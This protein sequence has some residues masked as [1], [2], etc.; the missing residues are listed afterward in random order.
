M[1]GWVKLSS[2]GVFFC[3]HARVVAVAAYDATSSEDG[4]SER[5]ELRRVAASWCSDEPRW[6]VRVR[7]LVSQ[8]SIRRSRSEP[9]VG[10]CGVASI[11][12]QADA[13]RARA[14]PIAGEPSAVSIG[15]A[16][17][18]AKV[19]R[20][21]GKTC[22]VIC[23]RVDVR[24]AIWD[25]VASNVT[26]SGVGSGAGRTRA[27]VRGVGTLAAFGSFELDA[28]GVDTKRERASDAEL[29]DASG[30][31]TDVARGMAAATVH[32]GSVAAASVLIERAGDADEG[33]R[34]VG[35]E[36]ATVG[37]GERRR[38]ADGA[39]GGERANRGH[40]RTWTK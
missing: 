24:S 11:V 30:V 40:R 9:L 32:D 35:S 19:G 26:A 12:V 5:R 28:N 8:K 18:I 17:T 38:G 39:A 20:G 37:E 31:G 21:M 27:V 14:V 3:T 36:G 15:V 33:V 6:G 1:Q 34:I 7:E 25:V 4:R 13:R 16:S 22:G 23:E 2:S 29:G 10:V